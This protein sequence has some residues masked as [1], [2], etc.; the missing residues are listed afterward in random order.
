MRQLFSDDYFS[1]RTRL[2]DACQKAD[3]TVQTLLHPSITDQRGE[4]AIDVVRIGSETASKVIFISSGVHGTEGTV[5]SGVQLGLIEQLGQLRVSQDVA[6]VIIHAVNPVGYIN[7]TRCNEDNI[8]L[9][10]NFKDFRAPLMANPDYDSLRDALCSNYLD[11]DKRAVD[12]QKIQQYI[13][14]HSMAALTEKVLKG[15]HSDAQG[16]FYGG[17]CPS[18]S[19]LM[20][21][22][23]VHQHAQHAQHVAIIDVHTGIGP[24]GVGLILRDKVRDSQQGDM[25]PLA[26]V[27]CTVLDQLAAHQSKIKIILEF[28]TLSFDQVL[29][30]LRDDNWLYRHPDASLAQRNTI[31]HHLKHALRVDEDDWYAAI[32]Q[33]SWQLLI[34]VEAEMGS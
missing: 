4:V 24:R 8:D 19:R 16:I 18:W 20:I 12:D 1:A 15:Q 26:G 27:M 29:C 14:D 22:Q 28:G 9:N 10:R 7:L 33:Q 34:D 32:W 3:L 13:D 21:E 5:G 11:G 30:S 25:A 23:I 31:K 6:Y 17:I 2:L